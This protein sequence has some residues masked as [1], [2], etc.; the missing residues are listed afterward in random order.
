MNLDF[1]TLGAKPDI[2]TVTPGADGASGVYALRSGTDLCYDAFGFESGF[3]A[4]SIRKVADNA[5]A[6]TMSLE[7]S[8]SED[9]F[10]C[11]YGLPAGTVADIAANPAD[12]N[13]QFVTDAGTA[14]ATMTHVK[15]IGIAQMVGEAEVPGPGDNE[16]ASGKAGSVVVPLATPSNGDFSESIGCYS[17]T[18]DL[19]TS[20]TTNP[21]GF[22]L[23]VHTAEFPNGALRGQLIKQG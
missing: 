15:L 20:I 12:Y 8:T 2:D 1:P 9:P 10:G 6:V 11:S 3:S 4:A 23:N 5:T 16:A 18:P 7:L 17:V 21:S 22:Y 14:K 13:I 19:L